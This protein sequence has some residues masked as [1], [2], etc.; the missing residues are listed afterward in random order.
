MQQY[1]DN[2]LKLV[3]KYDEREHLYWNENLEFYFLCNDFFYWGCAD[4]EDI[5]SQEDVDLFEQCI[6][7]CKAI[8]E[9]GEVYAKELYCS[10]RAK[11]RPQG[12]YY[13]AI[14]KRFWPLFDACGPERELNMGNPKPHPTE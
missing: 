1:K 10:R 6:K 12:A 3:A 5:T 4:A 7:D 9:Q 8:A 11:M 14:D 2:L 13:E